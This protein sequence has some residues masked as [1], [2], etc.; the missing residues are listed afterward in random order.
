M[1]SR[2]ALLG[3]A[4]AAVVFAATTTAIVIVA[5]RASCPADGN[6]KWNVYAGT[7]AEA[8][9]C[10]YTTYPVV[11]ITRLPDGGT[12]WTYQTAH[13]PTDETVPPAGFNP[14]TA[15]AAELARY[16]LPLAPAT[17]SA[18]PYAHWLNMIDHIKS[19]VQPPPFLVS[20]PNS[21]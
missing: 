15:S 18:I 12:Q 3:L 1:R 4:C 5:T 21:G 16:G 6:P 2:K 8:Q 17:T 19:W 10:G 11:S 20:A 14:R 7:A 9:A 13:G